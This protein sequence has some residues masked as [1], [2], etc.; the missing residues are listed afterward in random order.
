[1]LPF[2]H[3]TDGA[4]ASLAATINWRTKLIV[5]LHQLFMTGRSRMVFL[6]SHYSELTLQS[7]QKVWSG[8]SP[9][10]TQLLTLG[11]T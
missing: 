2:W 4:I 5:T 11:E 9:V 6:K 1:M 3:I 7:L 10:P 8:G